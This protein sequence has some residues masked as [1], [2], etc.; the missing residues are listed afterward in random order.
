MNKKEIE[1]MI[2]IARQSGN[3]NELMRLTKIMK[4]HGFNLDCIEDEKMSRF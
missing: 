4:L 2:K 3:F 1:N